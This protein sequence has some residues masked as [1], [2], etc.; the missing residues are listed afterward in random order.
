MLLAL[1]NPVFFDIKHGKPFQL[2]HGTGG[3]SWLTEQEGGIKTCRS[4][5]LLRYG[6]TIQ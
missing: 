4:I 1:L 6:T 3:W 2:S 5:G